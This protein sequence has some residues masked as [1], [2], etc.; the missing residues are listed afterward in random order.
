MGFIK[1]ILIG[2]ISYAI[3]LELSPGLGNIWYRTGVDG[4]KHIKI[5]NLLNIM[6]KPLTNKDLWTPSLWDTN[7]FIFITVWTIVY[8]FARKIF[9][10]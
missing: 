4:V 6:I 8:R 7:Y 2:T 1:T 9:I 10:T 5:F 3:Y